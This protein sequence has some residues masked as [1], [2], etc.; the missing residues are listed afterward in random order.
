MQLTQT[1]ELHEVSVVLRSCQKFRFRHYTP[2]STSQSSELKL[3]FP[4]NPTVPDLVAA[5]LPNPKV[6]SK[7]GNQTWQVARKL[8]VQSNVPP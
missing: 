7:K 8:P 4:D 5:L 2:R 6:G 3:L 1:V